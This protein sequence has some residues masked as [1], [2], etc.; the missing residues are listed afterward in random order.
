MPL[1][2]CQILFFLSVTGLGGAKTL[3]RFSKIS[4]TSLSLQLSKGEYRV[5]TKYCCILMFPQVSIIKSYSQ[6]TWGIVCQLDQLEKPVRSKVIELRKLTWEVFSVIA[7][8][9]FSWVT[10][11]LWPV[12]RKT[13]WL[14]HLR[15]Y[16]YFFP[17]LRFLPYFSFS[18]WKYLFHWFIYFYCRKQF[19]LKVVGNSFQTLTD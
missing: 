12:R 10:G 11:R 15:Q 17:F 3:N 13:V 4:L 1:E 9:P 18:I 6:S 14:K 16:L 5:S 7:S 8:R 19:T 2:I